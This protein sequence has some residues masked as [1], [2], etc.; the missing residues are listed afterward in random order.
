M[1]TLFK[2]NYNIKKIYICDKSIHEAMRITSDIHQT[3]KQFSVTVQPKK[4]HVNWNL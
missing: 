2:T 1:N 4:M 3:N